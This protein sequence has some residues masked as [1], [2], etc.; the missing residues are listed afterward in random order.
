M[1]ALTAD[2][3]YMTTEN[4]FGIFVGNVWIQDIASLT[5]GAM[6]WHAYPFGSQAIAEW[7]VR[8]SQDLTFQEFHAL[9][10]AVDERTW[11]TTRGEPV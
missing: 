8:Q 7:V 2:G 3:Y 11:P 1:H 10:E 6:P 4:P 9:F 5:P